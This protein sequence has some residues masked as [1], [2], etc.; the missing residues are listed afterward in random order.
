MGTSSSQFRLSLAATAASILGVVGWGLG[1]AAPGASARGAGADL[2]WQTYEA[3]AMAGTG[4]V[5]GPKYDPFL[6]ETEASGQ[7][8]VRLAAAGEHVEFKARAEANTA[9]IRFSLPDARTGGGTST[10]LRLLVNGRVVASLSTEEPE[11]TIGVSRPG[12]YCAVAVG[13]PSAGGPLRLAGPLSWIVGPSDISND[14]P[15]R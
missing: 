5:L 2:P 12:I 10:A 7:Q 8:C 9:V 13:A 1:L 11:V 14:I 3:E 4:T 15:R 6:L